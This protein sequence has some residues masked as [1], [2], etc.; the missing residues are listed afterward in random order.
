MAAGTSVNRHFR[1]TDNFWYDEFFVSSQFPDDAHRLLTYTPIPRAEPWLYLLCIYI[2]QPLRTYLGCPMRITSGVRD[3]ELLRKIYRDRL[4]KMPEHSLHEDF[5]AADFT[6]DRLG[7][8]YA[9][10]KENLKHGECYMGDGFIHVTLPKRGY[11]KE[12]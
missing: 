5:I 6:C 9:Y 12:S 4:D 11:T 2:L 8:A 7:D 10:I 1:L 3:K